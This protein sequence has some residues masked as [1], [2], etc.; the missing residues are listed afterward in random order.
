MKSFYRKN[1]RITNLIK[2]AGRKKLIS[3]ELNPYK[4]IDFNLV[5][6]IDPS[7]C[8]VLWIARKNEANDP[9]RLESVIISK[10]L[11][12]RGYTVLV[13]VPGL[14]Y[15]KTK[16]KIILN[17]LKDY[18]VRNLFILRGVGPW[19]EIENCEFPFAVNLIQFVRNEFHNYF[20][21]V[22][23][24]FPH[25]HPATRT[26]EDEMYFLRQKVISGANIIMTQACLTP[27]RYRNYKRLCVK[28]AIDVP[29]ICGVL[30]LR[31]W[32]DF[33]RIKRMSCFIDKDVMKSAVVAKRQHNER[34]HGRNHTK[35]II[36]Q[37]L[38]DEL[39]TGVNILT[40]NYLE[41]AKNILEETNAKH[42]Q[43][44]PRR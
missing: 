12:R 11:V 30:M 13:H 40:Q 25:V 20:D 31:S 27:E 35:L 37:I 24:G 5:K 28:Y 42:Y 3:I 39:L 32:N 21:I 29:I 8:S 44:H 2:K 10:E 23:A 34:D 6:L 14:F 1:E 9:K 7:F 26:M 41:L 36:S 18:G 15:S 16:A 4:P 43:A 38:D 19:I 22:T 33:I 17:T